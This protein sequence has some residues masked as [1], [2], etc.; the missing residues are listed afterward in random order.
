[1]TTHELKTWPEFFGAVQW[2]ARDFVVMGIRM[3][4]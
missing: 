4:S 1:M 3:A 2:V